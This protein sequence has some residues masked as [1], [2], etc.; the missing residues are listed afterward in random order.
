MTETASPQPATEGAS[1]ARPALYQLKVSLL[2]TNPA[3]WRRI[4]VPAETTLGRLHRILQVVMGWTNSHL[5]VFS[6][7]GAQYAEPSPEWETP[8]KDERRVAL[9]RI[10]GTTGEAFVY[11]YDLGDSWEHQ[12]VL[13]EVRPHEPLG[14][15]AVCLGGERACPLEDSGGVGGYYEKLEVLKDRNHAEYEETKVWVESMAELMGRKGF[16]A[17]AFNVALVNAALRKLR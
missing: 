3:I 7:G 5:H 13:E 9:S 11:E 16:D 6:A 2:Q 10:I 14:Q 12:I 17:D 8:M 4:L 15:V 1:A